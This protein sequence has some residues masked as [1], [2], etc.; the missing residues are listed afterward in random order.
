MKASAST[1]TATT[2]AG[3][4]FTARLPRDFAGALCDLFH[5]A[6]RGGASTPTEIVAAVVAQAQRRLDKMLLGSPQGNALRELLGALAVEPD[7]ARAFAAHA[8]HWN[9]LPPDERSARKSQNREEHK[10]GRMASLPATDAQIGFLRRLGYDGPPPSDRAAA[11]RL[12]DERK[13]VRQ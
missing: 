9:Q 3:T 8:I 4:A 13:G 10:Q 2:D 11:S 12:I 5:Q 6:A 1:G 7:G